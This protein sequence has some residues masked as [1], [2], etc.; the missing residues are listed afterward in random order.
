MR[1]KLQ[2]IEIVKYLLLL[3]MKDLLS[4]VPSSC[5]THSPISA[6]L[7]DR[8]LTVVLVDGSSQMSSQV[9]GKLQVCLFLAGTPA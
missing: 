7:L 1:Q 8:M 4:F 5:R 6:K 3:S 9:G 2:I